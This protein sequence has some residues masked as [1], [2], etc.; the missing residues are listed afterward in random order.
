MEESLVE[1]RRRL[2]MY[3]ELSGNE[4]Q[5]SE[6]IVSELRKMGV[7]ASVVNERHA[8]VG[9]IKG[10]GT[11]NIGVRCLR[12]DMDALPIR[13]ANDVPYKSRSDGVM[14]ACGHDAHVAIQ[15]GAAALLNKYKDRFAGEIRLLFEPA[16]ETV[17]GALELV[18]AGYMKGA[19]AVFGLHMQ[20]D[21]SAGQVEARVGAMSG[22]SDNLKFNVRGKSAHGA[23]PERGTDA[24][25]AASNLVLALQTIVSRNASPFE[26]A[27][28]S[29]GIME[30]GTAGN[31]ICGNVY[32][33]GTLRTLSAET[34]ELALRRI[35]EIARGV[36]AAYGC[37][38]EAEVTAGYEAVICDERF[39]SALRGISSQMNAEY[40]TKEYP[41]LGVDSF[42]C[43]TAAAPGLY[44]NLGCGKTAGA[45]PL[46]TDAFDIDEKCLAI[47][48][49]LQTLLCFTNPL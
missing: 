30:G 3:P 9:I 45:L 44:Y 36:G 41:S 12:A 35:N 29:I 20:P 10:R 18:N 13:E 25:V 27:A 37:E 31:I 19:N 22:Y 49:C 28:L 8:V 5:T 23:Y 46:H 11:E 38:C 34:R 7:D 2:H 40:F 33:K 21:L 24:I 16:E 42:G 39:V 15:L 32:M 14:H 4:V 6:Y 43:L 26:S 48:A 1:W 47:G 17:G